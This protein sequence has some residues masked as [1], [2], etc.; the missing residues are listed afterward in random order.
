MCINPANLAGGGPALLG[1]AYVPKPLPF[2]HPV[3]ATKAASM[4]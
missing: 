1:A 2:D 3:L 4:L